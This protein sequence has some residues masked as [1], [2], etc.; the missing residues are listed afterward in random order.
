VTALP[1]EAAANLLTDF[2]VK[3]ALMLNPARRKFFEEALGEEG[4]KTLEIQLARLGEKAQA[5][6][7]A[8]KDVFVGI[9]LDATAATQD[10]TP[11]APAAGTKEAPVDATAT[12]SAA[13]QAAPADA[14]AAAPAAQAVP[15]ADATS[16]VPA[17]EALPTA[18]DAATGAPL[19]P[20]VEAVAQ[21]A[22]GADAMKAF[23]D[24]VG[25]AVVAALAPLTARLELVETG[26]SALKSSRD[27]EI[28]NAIRP[29]VGPTGV[30][31]PSLA[32]SNVVVD[33]EAIAAVREASAQ[34]ADER[35]PISKHFKAL[36]HAF[37]GIGEST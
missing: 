18:A 3:E 27:T 12:P 15:V 25:E 34:A 8:F 21:A 4:A 37:Q 33:A 16:P 20:T 32:T 2:G 24:I 13:P 5:E 19:P 28:A 10:V 36:T 22:A 30:I 29:Q 7:V 31:P 23:K 1:L 9:D 6:G 14:Q 35:N 26:I 11:G 17:G